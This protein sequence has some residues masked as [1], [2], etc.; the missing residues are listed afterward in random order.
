MSNWV[1]RER[2]GFAQG[3]THTSARLAA[4]VTPPLIVVMI[5]FVGWRGTF[6][7]LG[8]ISLCGRSSGTRIFVTIRETTPAL[9]RR[10][11]RNCLSSSWRRSALTYRGAI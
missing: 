10:C 7:I 4:A 11:W 3:F 9:R 6:A 8:C 1:P 5:P 2:R